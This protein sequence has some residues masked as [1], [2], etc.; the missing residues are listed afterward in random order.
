MWQKVAKFK[1][2]EYFRKALYMHTV[3]YIYSYSHM[4][5]WRQVA[6]RLEHCASNQKTAGSDTGADKVREESVT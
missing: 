6:S 1:G 4:Q 2:A 5:V 3:E